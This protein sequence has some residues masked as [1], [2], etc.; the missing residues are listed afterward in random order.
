M[1][2]AR[3]RVTPTGEI[4]SFPLRG[5]FTGN[6]G[7]LHSGREIVRFHGHNCWITCGLAFNGRW[8]EQWKPRRF[9][10]LYFY[11]EALSFAAGHRPCA[12]CRW[13][14][15]TAYRQ[16]WGDALGGELP[17]AG[18]MNHRLHGE[19]LHRGTHRRRTHELAWQGLPDGAYVLLDEAP[20]VVIG[21]HLARWTRDGYQDRRPRPARG[22]ATVLTPPS[23]VAV[24]T[25]G[26]PVQIDGAGL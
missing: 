16:A 13:R 19:R 11:D 9:T 7:I 6:R 1:A 3:N 15:Y 20:H 12:E 24:L 23:T 14:S 4:E 18:E 22:A 17:S 21:G 26:Y 5:A 8:N 2:A 25:A 10:W